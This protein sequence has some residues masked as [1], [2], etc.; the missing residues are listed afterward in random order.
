MALFDA[1]SIMDN[2]TFNFDI[3]AINISLHVL[4]YVPAFSV[5]W[6][7]VNVHVN[8]LAKSFCETTSRELITQL[9]PQH[10]LSYLIQPC[11]NGKFRCAQVRRKACCTLPAVRYLLSTRR[12]RHR[13]R[14]I[15][16]VEARLDR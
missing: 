16:E 9:C 5:V 3:N 6:G 13:I 15:A 10:T 1:L 11:C 14:G 12:R 8:G 4:N 2:E 7:F